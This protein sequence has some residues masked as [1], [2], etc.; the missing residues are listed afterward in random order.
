MPNYTCTLADLT[1]ATDCSKKGGL[2]TVYMAQESSIDWANM[3]DGV[4]YDNAT[5]VINQWVMLAG[6]TWHRVDF[7]ALLG[8]L[9]ATYTADNGYY[10]T[11]LLNLTL[12]GHSAANTVA[13]SNLINC[14]GL[15]FQIHDNNGLARVVGKELVNDSFINPLRLGEFSRHLD[16]TGAFG[17]RDDFSRDEFD[18]NALQRY[19]P[20]YS[21]VTTA[22][23]DTL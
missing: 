18:I 20:L 10:E 3:N 11:N 2:L 4:H 12:S 21:T 9:D 6:G 17:A 5:G 7:E 8:R 15:V 13:L 23:M 16:T 14:C 19:A 1:T 22:T